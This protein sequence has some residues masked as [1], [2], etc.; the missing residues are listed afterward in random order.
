MLGRSILSRQAREN[1]L[2][3]RAMGVASVGEHI[4]NETAMQARTR[5][6]NR[7]AKANSV[8]NGPRVEAKER[9]KK[10]RENPKDS[11]KDPKVP[12]AHANIKN[13]GISGLEKHEISNKL[14]NSGISANGTCLCH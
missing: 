9:V 1:G 8:S 4:F 2:Q 3:V 13:I 6:S 7:L 12:E 14:G 10:T 5:A 11:P